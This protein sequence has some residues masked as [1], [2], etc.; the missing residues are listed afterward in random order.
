M[1]RCL[2][3]AA[4]FALPVDSARA[5]GTD[6]HRTLGGIAKRLDDSGFRA[7][8]QVVDGVQ[9]AVFERALSP[10]GRGIP[11]SATKAGC[12]SNT[13]AWVVTGIRVV[14]EPGRD[15]YAQGMS[16]LI[17]R[18]CSKTPGYGKYLEWTVERYA[19]LEALIEGTRGFA[20]VVEMAEAI[21][22]LVP[23]PKGSL[24]P[25]PPSLPADR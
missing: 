3:L 21:E 10:R 19:G 12:E 22:R 17:H 5:Q 20:R 16:W 18:M 1:M 7:R 14:L 2:M 25:D 23:A 13:E 15:G 11:W 4:L 24:P 8:G 6:F 9:M